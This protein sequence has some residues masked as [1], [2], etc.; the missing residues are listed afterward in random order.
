MPVPQIIGGARVVAFAIIN[1]A[2]PRD[3]T[4]RLAY[5][6]A[7]CKHDSGNG[8]YLFFC[9]DN[10]HEFADTWHESIEEAQDQAEFEYAG[11][12]ANWVFV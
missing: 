9:G 3:S 12:T 8:Y 4:I 6:A 1:L 2:L 11:I 5:G 7:I 10:W